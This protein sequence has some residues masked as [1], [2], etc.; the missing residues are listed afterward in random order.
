VSASEMWAHG[1]ST[2][3]RAA[4]DATH[5]AL[6]ATVLSAGY[7][8]AAGWLVGVAAFQVSLASQHPGL[9]LLF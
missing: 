5:V 7:G 1:F 8:V 2:G 3:W 4:Q 6:A 9:S